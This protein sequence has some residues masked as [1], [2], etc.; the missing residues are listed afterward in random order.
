MLKILTMITLS[1]FRPI[2]LSS[3]RLSRKIASKALYKLRDYDKYNHQRI[4]QGKIKSVVAVVQYQCPD[5]ASSD[6][7]CHRTCPDKSDD[8]CRE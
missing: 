1:S 7:S 8:S 3:A 4:H 6:I 2:T 5:T